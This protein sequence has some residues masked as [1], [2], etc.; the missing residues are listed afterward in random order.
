[1]TR[2]ENIYC[3]VSGKELKKCNG[4]GLSRERR[5]NRVLCECLCGLSCLS[6][7]LRENG[8]KN[9]EIE[10]AIKLIEKTKEEIKKIGEEINDGDGE[11]SWHHP[12]KK[13]IWGSNDFIIPMERRTHTRLENNNILRA[14]GMILCLRMGVY[15]TINAA[16]IFN[17]GKDLTDAEIA[18]IVMRE[19]LNIRKIPQKTLRYK[20]LKEHP[21]RF[22]VEKMTNMLESKGVVIDR[23][24]KREN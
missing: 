15:A 4:N 13:A 16:F 2:D 5:K 24:S 14:E 6:A 1:L 19:E 9:E 3:I 11:A 12:V 8:E 22:Y 17:K 21:P 7:Q 10:Q 20:L 18:D 23:N